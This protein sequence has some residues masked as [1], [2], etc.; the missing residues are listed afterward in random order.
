[1]RFIGKNQGSVLLAGTISQLRPCLHSPVF[2]LL[3]IALDST[4]NGN[5]R[6]P[7]YRL[8]H[9]RHM[10]LM[11]GD[12]KFPTQ[13]LG[14]TGTGPHI[15]S[16]SVGFRSVP[17]KIGQHLL[18]F[19]GQLSM[20]TMRVGKQ[21]LRSSSTGVCQPLALSRLRHSQ[22]LGNIPVDPTKLSQLHSSKSSPLSP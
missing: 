5:L 22:G 19:R 16:N 10:I 13:N 7:S 4:S 17:Q 11:K 6:G 15:T 14:N 21:S 1:A 18:L 3:F 8:E 20:A 12:A 2:D 9:S